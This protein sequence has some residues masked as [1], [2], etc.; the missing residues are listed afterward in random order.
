MMSTQFRPSAAKINA[1]SL[2]TEA[3]T[4]QNTY[5][6]PPMPAVSPFSSSINALACPIPR[7]SA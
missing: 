3:A 1:Q 2:A 6:R 5:R 7:S 4:G